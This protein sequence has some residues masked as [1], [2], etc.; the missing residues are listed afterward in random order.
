MK[1]NGRGPIVGLVMAGG[2]ASR[3]GECK[4]LLPVGG[5]SA[6]EQIAT[7]MREAAVREV[8]VVTGGYEERIHAE[9]LRLKCRPVYNPAFRSGMFSS[10]L[11]GVRALPEETEAFFF[12]PADTPLIKPFTYRTLIEAL[13]GDDDTPQVV[14]PTFMGEREHPPLIGRA[15]IDPILRWSGEGGLRGLLESR[16]HASRDVPTADRGTSLDMDTPGDYAALKTYAEDEWYPDDD[17]CAEL[18]RIAETPER[19]VRHTRCV[20]DIAARI[21]SALAARGLVLNDRLLRAACLLHDIAKGQKDHEA[22]GAHWL[23][24]RGYAEVAAIATTHKDLP[25]KNFLREPEVLYLADKL[26]D[27]DEISSLEARMV[28]MAIRFSHD[29]EA[30]KAARHRIA[31][32]MEIQ[33]RVEN[34]TGRKAEEILEK[35]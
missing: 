8:V 11:T 17:E 18:L 34:V 31:R 16:P 9:A 13:C 28:R 5:K 35:A 3:M 26:S 12:L 10:V 33:K 25:E 23:A 24:E 30:L 14:Y 21:S 20:A 15:L 6:L 4:V 29:A 19:V 7:R 27:G 32:A 22:R 2:L 1:K